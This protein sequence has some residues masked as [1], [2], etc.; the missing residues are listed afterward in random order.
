MVERSPFD[1]LTGTTLGN[2]CLEELIEQNEASSVFRAR[3]TVA[4]ALFR[5]LVIAVPPDLKPEDRIVYLGRFQR[6]A[7]Q[8]SALHHQ[9]ILPL[10]DYAIHNAIGDPKGTS[11]PYLVSPYLSVKSL[12]T[13]L[14]RKGPIDATLTGRYLD[15]ITSALEYAHQKAILH[16]NLTTNCIFINQ[17][18]NLLVADFG[19]IH[20]LLAG[21]RD[22]RSDMRKGVY[23]MSEASAPAP[24]Q[25]LGQATD[26]YT[27]VYAL[28]AVIYRMLTGHR[29]F[30]G[31]TREEMIQLHLQAPIPSLSVWRSDLP[32]ALDDVIA[33]A[34]AKEAAQ[35]YL[36]PGEVA[37]AYHQIV[38]PHDMQRVPFSVAM[39][40]QGG[41]VKQGG[42]AQAQG[43]SVQVQGGGK[44]R[45]YITGNAGEGR[46]LHSAPI[47][48]RRVL[49]FIAAGGGVA[50]AVLAVAVF[51]KNYLGGNTA[52]ANTSSTTI[53]PGNTP[54]ANQT[55][56]KSQGN[57]LALTSNLPNNS[58]KTFPISGQSNP[59][60]IVHLA[61][62]RF[63]AFD[64][65]CTHAGCQV[66]YS[67]QDK[68][69]E[70]PCHGA[71]FDPAKNA[72]VVQGPAQTPLA[73][74]KITVNADGTITRG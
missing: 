19:I 72:A 69:L 26:T 4:G 20:M 47:S 8:I 52:P 57:V 65:T 22:N 15:Q 55:S 39:Q 64:T 71:E 53:S 74:L 31:K 49:G 25:I 68:L 41:G 61:D 7:N 10:V 44:P 46:S 35:R 63:V 59:G 34:M 18:G 28:G 1:S 51:G 56:T 29:V 14:A 60:I 33:R 24:E 3:N 37:N 5:L 27:D 36:H 45:P 13:F 11:W 48:R 21:N 16:R 12:S 2:Y 73:S 70:C 32:K 23:G 54:I 43:G 50:A 30:R 62:G 17:D 38:A 67:P 9:H 66:N 6:E 40:A 58:A 42:N